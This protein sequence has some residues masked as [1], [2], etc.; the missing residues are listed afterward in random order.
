M[1]DTK[2]EGQDKDGDGSSDDEK[3]TNN[4][5]KQIWLNFQ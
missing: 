4:K 5:L 2:K 3:W 1:N